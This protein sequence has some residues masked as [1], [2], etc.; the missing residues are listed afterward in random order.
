MVPWGG[1]AA[2]S[3]GSIEQHDWRPLSGHGEYGAPDGGVARG[4]RDESRAQLQGGDGQSSLQQQGA[5]KQGE[6]ATVQQRFGDVQR[7]RGSDR[8]VVQ[9]DMAAD[10]AIAMVPDMA[11]EWRRRT[12]LPC[13]G[14]GLG[15]IGPDIASRQAR[16]AKVARRSLRRADAAGQRFNA[17]PPTTSQLLGGRGA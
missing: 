16:A 1:R 2:G 7:K 17:R 8:G 12:R 13:G 5:H 4:Q 15:G 3:H 10:K 6:E 14:R 11:G 9:A